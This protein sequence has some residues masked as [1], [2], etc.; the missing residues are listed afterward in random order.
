MGYKL[1]PITP[2]LPLSGQK[3]SQCAYRCP[4]SDTMWGMC[5]QCNKYILVF[6]I[7]IMTFVT[8]MAVVAKTYMLSYNRKGRCFTIIVSVC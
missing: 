7:T 4:E 2:L 3:V 5:Q 1:V 6:V 8:N